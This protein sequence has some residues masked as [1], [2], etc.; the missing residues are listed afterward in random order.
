MTPSKNKQW[1]TDPKNDHWSIVM[2]QNNLTYTINVWYIYYLYIYLKKTTKW[3]VAID[4]I[5]DEQ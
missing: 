4:P 2:E 3:S 5:Q 1:S